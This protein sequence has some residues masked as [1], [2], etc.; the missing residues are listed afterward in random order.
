MLANGKEYKRKVGTKG[1]L[2]L[3]RGVATSTALILPS[4]ER[5]IRGNAV[6]KLVN[7]ANI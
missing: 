3:R 7:L 6:C 2:H 4:A 5:N 1:T